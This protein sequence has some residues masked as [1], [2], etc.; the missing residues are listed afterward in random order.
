L[1]T[2]WRLGDRGP[3]NALYPVAFRSLR[4][5]ASALLSRE[6]PGAAGPFTLGAFCYSPG[7]NRRSFVGSI[8][9][10][11]S[12]AAQI[13]PQPPLPPKAKITSSVMLWTLKGSFEE[14]LE[15]AGKAGIQSV[16][17]VGEH[18]K[19][20]DADITRVK[21]LARSLGVAMDTISS[22]P[23]WKSRPIS[24]VEPAQR[25]NLVKEVERQLV[26]AKKL[27]IPM[28]LL[29]SGDAIPGRT[30]QEQWSSLVEGCKRCGD[31]AAKAGITL[32]V[33]PLNTKVNHKGYY[34]E[35]CVEGLRLMKEVNHPHVRLLFDIYHE[36][37]QLGDVTRTIQAT[38]PYV[39][40]FHI[41]DNPGRNDPGTGEM[42]YDNIYKAIKRTGYEGYI[43]MEY[44]PLG[45]PVKSLEKAVNS[46]RSSLA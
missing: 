24:M 20:T 1:H 23:Q 35:S 11:S 6:R 39:K 19:W 21:K 7:M 25:E 13:T 42:N 43:T 2:R 32:I 16:E 10:A 37:V 27:E 46:M 4:A 3:G 5:I 22:T 9:V 28:A 8:A 38:A 34:L 36:Q 31:V 40:V 33:E 26:F 15:I 17:L 18:E 14:K 29:M 30:Y 41:A 12:A 45:D 44:I